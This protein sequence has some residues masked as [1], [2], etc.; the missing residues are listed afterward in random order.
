[1]S[2]F[3]KGPYD[4]LGTAESRRHASPPG[5]P[6]I[7]LRLAQLPRRQLLR[8]EL[9]PDVA[10]SER[11]DSPPRD[12]VVDADC[13]ELAAECT[14][15][16]TRVGDIVLVRTASTRASSISSRRWILKRWRH[17]AFPSSS[18]RPPRC[19]SRAERGLRCDRWRLHRVKFHF[20]NLKDT[21][22]SERN[23]LNLHVFGPIFG[24]FGK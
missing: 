22:R 17:P 8:A 2:P 5:P 11:L 18:S 16:A 3:R 21:I 19:E 4:R 7:R 14:G 9:V 23:L 13:P 15:I 12:F 1:M 10:A 24:D 20:R 6:A